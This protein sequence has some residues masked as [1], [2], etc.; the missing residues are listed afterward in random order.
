MADNFNNDTRHNKVARIFAI[1][2]LL[3]LSAMTWYNFGLLCRI[4]KLVIKQ[5]ETERWIIL[6][7]NE[8]EKNNTETWQRK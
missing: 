5:V 1:I 4:S 6:K 2:M 8:L 7:I 3:F